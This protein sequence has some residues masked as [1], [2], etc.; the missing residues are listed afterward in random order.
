MTPV[1]V[2]NLNEDIDVRKRLAENLR[3]LSRE[4]RH[5]WRVT[6]LANR[7]CIGG[8]EDKDS[9]DATIDYTVRE[10]QRMVNYFL[11]KGFPFINL[12]VCILGNAE[13]KL[14]QQIF[15]LLPT[16]LDEKFGNILS[17][18]LNRGLEQT[19]MLC[20]KDAINQ[21]HD[22]QH[23]RRCVKFLEQL[24]VMMAKKKFARV[25]LYQENQYV[26]NRFYCQLK[27]NELTDLLFQYL[28]SVYFCGDND[29]TVFGNDLATQ[30]G[31][32][33]LGAASVFY[34]GKA[35]H[36]MYA[37]NIRR[38][39]LKAMLRDK[40]LDYDFINDDIAGDDEIARNVAKVG[41][42]LKSGCDLGDV[43][44][45]L[46]ENP[47]PHPIYN[48]YR[49]N[50]LRDYFQT[51]LK[52]LPPTLVKRHQQI[53]Y[54]LRYKSVDTM[55]KNREAIYERAA[56][57]IRESAS[58]FIGSSYN[59]DVTLPQTLAYYDAM[60][61]EICK[62]KERAK[63]DKEDIVKCPK[64]INDFYLDFKDD[65]DRTTQQRNLDLVKELSS[66]IEYEPT[67]LGLISRTAV[68]SVVIVFSLMY[69]V[70][71]L[72][73]KMSDSIKELS[74][75]SVYYNVMNSEYSWVWVTVGAIIPWIASFVKYFRNHKYVM[76]LKKMLLANTLL[77]VNNNMRQDYED[78]VDYLYNDLY[79]FCSQQ[80]RHVMKL[81]DKAKNELAM[82]IP[83]WWT[84]DVKETMFNQHLTQAKFEGE[85]LV[86][87]PELVE[88]MLYLNRKTRKLS[89]LTKEDY[90]DMLQK[91]FADKFIS[92]IVT[93]PGNRLFG[94][95]DTDYEAEKATEDYEMLHRRIEKCFTDNLPN[96]PKDFADFH[97]DYGDCIT[98]RPLYKMAEI[99]GMFISTNDEEPMLLRAA[100]KEFAAKARHELFEMDE[101]RRYELD[102]LVCKLHNTD[103]YLFVV[104][105]Q[106]IEDQIDWRLK[107]NYEE[108][109]DLIQ[110]A[111]SSY[112]DEIFSQYIE[113]STEEEFTPW[114]ALGGINYEYKA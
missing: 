82:E 39:L 42:K 54:S 92:E 22:L 102:P 79:D 71:Y 86:K 111:P 96:V 89:E 34:D 24:N 83:D 60:Q 13:E 59:P 114:D 29:A 5:C 35:Q 26:A 47:D 85:P 63:E 6:N 16:I 11:E 43:F 93:L 25:V 98:F 72:L 14:T 104:T 64:I 41:G 17:T 27:T 80:K 68:L 110:E 112:R 9:F 46:Y 100:D 36:N 84:V 75:Y 77:E 66:I 74:E 21:S 12:Q 78:Q 33:S 40:N 10:G 8:I 18:H 49:Y 2:I 38:N 101:A 65:T 81:I 103:P 87:N 30:N 55:V 99:N 23:K 31:Y 70:P 19:G 57:T 51:Y 97:R 62:Y 44:N 94:K 53:S 108:E 69:F 15:H 90:K 105:W 20:V 88:P 91:L 61:E 56:S 28:L 109:D 76:K 67:L 52:H 45:K 48:F 7:R 50:L 4:Q 113:D 95:E 106:K 1:W 3:K 32:Y 107:C 58:Y 37:W 73:E